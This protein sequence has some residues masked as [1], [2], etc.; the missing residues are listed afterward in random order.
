M[1]RY[2]YN[3]SRM[4]AKN[5]NF[6]LKNLRRMIIPIM[7]ESDGVSGDVSHSV[8]GDG[9]ICHIFNVTNQTVPADTVR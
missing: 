3:I 5:Y 9:L 7:L 8:S 4:P 2:I 1:D 6:T